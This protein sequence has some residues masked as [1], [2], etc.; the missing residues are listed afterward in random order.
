[1]LSA[2]AEKTGNARKKSS[3]QGKWRPRRVEA[4]MSGM[5]V[6]KGGKSDDSAAGTS[7][8]NTGPAD[9]V[10][11][12]KPSSAQLRYLRMGIHEPGGKLP[13]FDTDGREIKPAT[14][15]SCIEKGWAEPWFANPIKPDWLVCRLTDA[16]RG[17]VGKS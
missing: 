7:D 5:V 12:A 8:K 15:R 14:I 10:G 1:L 2:L 11:Q 17:A 16:G 9:A 3:L 13:L 6:I 4:Q